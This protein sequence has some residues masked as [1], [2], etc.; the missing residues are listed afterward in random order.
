M[1]FA[2]AHAI[3]PMTPVG[4]LTIDALRR[5]AWLQLTTRRELQR[6]VARFAIACGIRCD[7]ADPRLLA[8]ATVLRACRPNI[9]LAHLAIDRCWPKL[10][11][12]RGRFVLCWIAP[13]DVL[14]R[15]I[16]TRLAVKTTCIRDDLPSALSH[17]EAILQ[18]LAPIGPVPQFTICRRSTF[19]GV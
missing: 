17:T 10:A 15:R 19:R 11:M 4:P 3:T 18:T 14:Q 12:F 8:R 6:S 16:R 1:A 5:S 7:T 13:L 9:P 2:L